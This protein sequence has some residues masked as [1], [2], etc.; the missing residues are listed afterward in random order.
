[1]DKPQKLDDL[2]LDDYAEH[3]ERKGKINMKIVL[4][5]IV[6]ELTR[7]FADP[8]GAHRE[9]DQKELFYKMTKMHPFEL[10]KGSLVSARVTK[11]TKKKL[12]CRLECGI[13]GT[14]FIEDFSDNQQSTS[15]PSDKYHE[16]MVIQ[17]KVEY[18]N[19]EKQGGE[20][21]DKEDNDF[22]KLKLTVKPAIVQDHIG[23]VKLLHPST[24]LYFK[25]GKLEST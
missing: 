2:D 24:E 11:V 14:V 22:T 8:R 6:N 13:E 18:T 1:M 20:A 17:A 12:I 7:P 16:G 25:R 5:F 19:F 15:D 21:K 4:D 10:Q 3:L 9:M 23:T